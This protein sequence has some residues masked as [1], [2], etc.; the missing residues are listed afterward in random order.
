MK[1]FMVCLVA[2]LLVVGCSSK[3]KVEEEQTL[4]NPEPVAEEQVNN[5][6]MS[7]D[8]AG[9][10]SGSINGLVT[11]NFEYDKAALTAEAKAGLKGNAEW[12][13]TNAKVNIQIEGHCDSRGS[14][15][16]NLSL[17][18]RRAQSVKNYLTG[19]GVAGSRLTIISY[20][21]EKPLVNAETEEAWAKNRR[22]NFVPLAQ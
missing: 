12:L 3:K 16:Y 15:E 14:I 6:P 11:V 17:G 18:E 8:P 10:D 2:T 7:F 20:G 13:K 19:L 1:K 9:S 21:E 22:A 5:Q 4:T